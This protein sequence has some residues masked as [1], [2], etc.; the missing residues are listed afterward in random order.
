MSDIAESDDSSVPA[1]APPAAGA[2]GTQQAAP[3]TGKSLILNGQV[4]TPVDQRHLGATLRDFADAR[5]VAVGTIAVAAFQDAVETK[6]SLTARVDNLQRDLSAAQERYHEERERRLLADERLTSSGRIQVSSQLALIA[7][8]LVSGAGLPFVLQ[9][10][11][12][13]GQGGLLLA[14]GVVLVAVG[15]SITHQPKSGSREVG[16]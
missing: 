9:A 4:A 14:I 7:G 10:K 6:V 2:E 1:P 12:L 8:S 16:R 11:S 13:S 15:L 3:T 5:S